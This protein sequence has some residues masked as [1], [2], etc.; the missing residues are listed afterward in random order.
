[1]NDII[2]LEAASRYAI[3]GDGGLSF[4]VIED[5]TV[6]LL[7]IN[8]GRLDVAKKLHSGESIEKLIKWMQPFQHLIAQIPIQDLLALS[9]NDHTSDF[10]FTYT[11]DSKIKRFKVFVN[12]DE[13]RT[14]LLYIL[15]SHFPFPFH[16][17]QKS[18][19]LFR[20]AWSY[21]VGT[22]F[23]IAMVIFFGFYWDASL[24]E[25]KGVFDWICMTLGQKGCTTVAAAFVIGTLYKARTYT[26]EKNSK[27][28]YCQIQKQHSTNT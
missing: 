5:A 26:V 28:H 18:A 3:A 13:A 22:V 21:L 9:W 17:E 2:S 20:V 25:K 15:Q 16:Y 24:F 14:T 6:I 11:K 8:Y 12:S 27:I 23:S 7:R 19:G 4:I 10:T 1:M